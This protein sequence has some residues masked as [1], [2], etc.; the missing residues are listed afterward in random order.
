MGKPLLALLRL[1]QPAAASKLPSNGWLVGVLVQ[2][3]A[4][5]SERKSEAG[6]WDLNREALSGSALLLLFLL[7]LAGRK[8]NERG[9]SGDV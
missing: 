3:T 2:E 4:R 9:R 5:G 8:G 7:L 6:R 1:Q